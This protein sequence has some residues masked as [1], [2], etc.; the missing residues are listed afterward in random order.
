MKINRILSLLTLVIGLGAAS[1]A[2]SA[3]THVAVAANFTAAAKEIAAAYEE[4][5][6]DKVVLSFGSTG[7]LATQIVNGAPYD[8]FLA[9]DSAR[10]VKL[11][12]DGYT[13]SSHPRFT[14]AIG[15]LVLWSPDPKTVDA[16]GEVL[17]TGDFEK[18]AVANPKT[19][20]YGAAAMETLEKL[21]L[22]DS[23]TPK[24]VFGQ[25][26][27]QTQQFISTGAAAL[28]FIALAQV[29]NLEGGSKWI[30]PETLY[31]PINQ[32]AVLLKKGDDNAA[33]RAF[34]DYLQGAEAGAIIA[35]YGYATEKPGS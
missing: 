23:L 28:G 25:N 7:Q 17:K 31:A 29:V 8:V 14:Y 15:K 1:P 32:Q 35:R 27:A 26:V 24:L 33:A 4:K 30:V 13:G 6:G 22:T 18:L 10:P 9:A 11:E 34:V 5:T 20:P 16:E 3:E 2:L 21:G 12:D 19:A